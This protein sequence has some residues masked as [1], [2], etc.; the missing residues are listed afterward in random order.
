MKRLIFA[1]LAII[2]MLMT[3]CQKDNRELIG[4]KDG[5]LQAC[6]N[7]YNCVC[8]Q[9][10]RDRY[11]MDPIS[12]KGTQEEAREKLLSVIRRM[13]QSTLVKATPDYVHVEYRSSFFEFVDD[14]EF[15]FDDSAK[16]IHFR[17]ASRTGYYDFNV[18]RNRMEDIRR[19]FMAPG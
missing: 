5:K 17:S 7:A 8:T 13:I 19:R 14:V 10:P 15:L 16:L 3:G 11:R 4:L 18:N 12:Y 1:F 9:D 2:L 6:P